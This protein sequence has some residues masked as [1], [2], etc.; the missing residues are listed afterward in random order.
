MGPPQG[1][2]PKCSIHAIK[3]GR[4]GMILIVLNCYVSI[5]TLCMSIYTLRMLKPTK[6]LQ[7]QVS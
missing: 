3:L 1:R 6:V 4:Q 7:L 5:Y 2:N